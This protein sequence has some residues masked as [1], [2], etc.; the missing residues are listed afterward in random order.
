MVEVEYLSMAEIEKLLHELVWDYRKFYT[1]AVQ[2]LDAS[3]NDEWKEFKQNQD[4]S[5]RAWSTLKAA[6]G[7][8]AQ[9]N[10]HLVKG[11]LGQ[12]RPEANATMQSEA[13]RIT[14]Q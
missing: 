8:H 13:E 7:H 5:K 1:G 10:E 2:A 3:D 6:F 12:G 14:A 11:D 4:D 9:F